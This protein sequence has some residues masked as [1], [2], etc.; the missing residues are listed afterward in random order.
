VTQAFGWSIAAACIGIDHAEVKAGS[1]GRP[2]KE[3]GYAESGL[4]ALV[5]TVWRMRRV[6][7]AAVIGAALASACGSE[8]TELAGAVREPLPEVGALSLPDLSRG[9]TDFAFRAAEDGI[10]VVYFGF[11][12][13]PDVCPTTLA[14]V[15]SVLA[16][17]GDG[18]RRVSV[19]MVT[20]DPMRDTGDVLTGYVQSFVP[21]AHALRTEDDA[22]LRAVAE[23]F[24]VY[25]QVTTAEEGTIDVTHTASLFAVDD[26][27]NLRVTWTFG[28]PEE[29]VAADLRILLRSE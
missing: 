7:L 15:R 1:A 26:R 8:P 28:T 12:S 2:V 14:E 18:A 21:G 4:A 27:G 25:Y 5:P 6:L 22:A 29:D 10:L 11:T 23:T 20:V 9:G 16:D 3:A 19:A 13:C 17:L 24:G